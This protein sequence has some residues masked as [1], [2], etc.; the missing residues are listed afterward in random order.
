MLACAGTTEERTEGK[1][2]GRKRHRLLVK[3]IIVGQLVG[4][5]DGHTT[6]KVFKICGPHLL[7]A[8]CD[9]EGGRQLQFLCGYSG[10]SRLRNVC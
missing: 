5:N 7:H 8:S 1:Q 2:R 3:W 10:E 9:T 4:H 6:I